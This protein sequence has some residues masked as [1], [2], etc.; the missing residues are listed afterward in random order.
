M[1]FSVNGIRQE[2][3]EKI[4]VDILVCVDALPLARNILEQHNII[5]LSINEFTQ[6]H[7]EFWDI[8]FTIKRNLEDVDIVTKFDDVQK[9]SD[10]FT[11]VGFDLVT[12]NS[13]ANPL[14]PS[15]IVEIIAKSKADEEVK[16]AAEKA[17]AEKRQAQ[18]KKL[19]TDAQMQEAKKI[20]A[21]VFEKIDTSVKR[22][23]GQIPILAMNKIKNMT[24]ELKKLRMGTNV[25][26][27]KDLVEQLFDILEDIDNTRYESQKQLANPIDK[28]SIITDME[29]EHELERMQYTQI[30]K[31][32]HANIPLRNQD[33]KVFGEPAV[34]RKLLQKEFIHKVKDPASILYNLVD[35]TEFTLLILVTLLGVTTMINQIFL[36]TSAGLGL[37]YALITI[38]IRGLVAFFANLRKKR[39]IPRLIF[40]ILL[41][42]LAHYLIMR[43][44]TSNFAL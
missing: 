8:Y 23:T 19:Y 3:E 37:A 38:G 44:M 43:V 42:I 24:E 4:A 5:V 22:A 26:T 11:S 2:K 9:A 34:Y 10:F 14:E 28:D 33:Y 31:E 32:L 12:I 39:N 30:L 13:Y 27:V 40:L 35:I 6:E 29:I 36:I 1:T 21:K 16:K 25:E 17:L 41:A 15:R 7:K 18:Q 20:L